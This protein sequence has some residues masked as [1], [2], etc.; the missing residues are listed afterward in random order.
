MFLRFTSLVVV[1]AFALPARADDVPAKR[2]DGA[3]TILAKLREPWKGP[4][5]L[6][7]SVTLHVTK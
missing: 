1:C 3:A 4:T 2:P 5:G 7:T 6:D